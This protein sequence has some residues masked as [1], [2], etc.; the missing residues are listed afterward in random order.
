[1]AKAAPKGSG[2]ASGK[3]SGTKTPSPAYSDAASADF[4]QNRGRMAWPVHYKSVAREFG[5]YNHAAGGQGRSDGIYLNRFPELDN[6]RRGTYHELSCAP[7]KEG[8]KVGLFRPI[9]LFPFP[10]QQIAEMAKGK[11]GVLVAEINA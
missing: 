4:V 9:T 3:G 8:I 1:M 6:E 5:V 2:S 7:E 11:K 10:Y